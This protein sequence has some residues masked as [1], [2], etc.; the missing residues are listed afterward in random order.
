MNTNMNTSGKNH[1]LLRS[2]PLASLAEREIGGF[3]GKLFLGAELG[4]TGCEASLN[5]VPA[6][7]G[8]P[9]LHTHK[10]NEELYIVVGGNGRFYVDGEEIAVGEG[11]CLRI[12]PDGVRGWCAGDRDLYFLC[13]QT[14]AGSLRQA[15]RDGGRLVRDKAS[16]MA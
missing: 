16:W 1:A 2:G 8:S 12:A 5:M 11:S 10:R 6:G 14:D 7:T 4:L 3:K 15:T 13:V 9:F